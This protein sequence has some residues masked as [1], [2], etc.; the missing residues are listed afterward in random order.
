[1]VPQY[2][3]ALTHVGLTVPDITEAMEWYERVIGFDVVAGP[4]TVDRGDGPRWRRVADLLGIEP[5]SVRIG[6][7]TAGNQVGVEFFEFE[8]T[9]SV[10]DTHPAEPG[11]FHVGVLDP[12]S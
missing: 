10:T 8:A 3:R 1:M 6:H 7:M 5:E 9:D 12:R 11:F 4:V 2:P